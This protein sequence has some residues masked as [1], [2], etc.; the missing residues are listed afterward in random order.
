MGNP[1]LR[2]KSSKSKI[3]RDKNK[4]LGKIKKIL[5]SIFQYWELKSL[6]RTMAMKELNMYAGIKSIK[7]IKCIIMINK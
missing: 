3:N 7:L 6:L 4:S 1:F 2:V 5:V